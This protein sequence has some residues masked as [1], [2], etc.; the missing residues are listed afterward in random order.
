MKAKLLMR[1][2]RVLEAGFVEVI[3]CKLP[4]PLSGSGHSL[5]VSVE[6]LLGDLLADVATWKGN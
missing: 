2:R 6:R 4:K 1:E 5:F 3:V